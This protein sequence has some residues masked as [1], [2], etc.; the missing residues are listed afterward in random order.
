MKWCSHKR[1]VARAAVTRPSAA[2]VVSRG[3]D[4]ATTSTAARL[5]V[6]FLQVAAL[7]PQGLSVLDVTLAK[8]LLTPQSGVLFE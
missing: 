7:Y 8:Y 4:V 6:S 3:L 2:F 1:Q 5:S